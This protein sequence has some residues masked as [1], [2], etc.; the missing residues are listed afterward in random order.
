MYNWLLTSSF[1]IPNQKS[2]ANNLIEVTQKLDNQHG[3]FYQTFRYYHP[4]IV[5]QVRQNFIYSRK[6]IQNQSYTLCIRNT[7]ASKN[8]A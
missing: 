5:V 1:G 3:N 6:L 4:I 7:A 2:L 8:R